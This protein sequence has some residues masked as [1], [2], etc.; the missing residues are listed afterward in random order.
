M[1]RSLEMKCEIKLFKKSFIEFYKHP[2]A[3]KEEVIFILCVIIPCVVLNERFTSKTNYV[4]IG[5]LIIFIG[6]LIYLLY[7]TCS[8]MKTQNITFEDLMERKL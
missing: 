5:A 1:E 2:M 7:D 4:Y 6:W 3:S 8:K